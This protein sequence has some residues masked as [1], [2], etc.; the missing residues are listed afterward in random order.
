MVWRAFTEPAILTRWMLGPS[1]WT[2]SVCEMDLREGGAFR[3]RW[4]KADGMAEFGFSV[5]FQDVQPNRLLRHAEVFDLGNM[6]G[7]TGGEAHVTVTSTEVSAG[8]EV[9]TRMTCASAEDRE[10]AV[11]SGMTDGMEAS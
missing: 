7:E 1:G 6:G 11:S 9:V 2:M 3:W 10:A 8:T 5:T 4:C